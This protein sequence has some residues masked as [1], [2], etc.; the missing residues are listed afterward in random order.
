EDFVLG[1]RRMG[2]LVQAAGDGNLPVSVRGHWAQGDR[3]LGVGGTAGRD[4]PGQGTTA[5]A[6]PAPG[7]K[8]GAGF[9]STRIERRKE[10]S[11]QLDSATKKLPAGCTLWL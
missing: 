3:G 7:R 8:R 4:R 5:A 2:D 1:S 6:L 11:D 10:G 9:S